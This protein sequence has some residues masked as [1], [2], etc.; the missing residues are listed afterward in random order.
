MGALA[1]AAALLLGLILA[2][3]GAWPLSIPLF[4]Y[5]FWGL[6]FRQDRPQE[7]RDTQQ[8]KPRGGGTGKTTV[9]GVALLGLS[10]VALSQGGQFSVLVFG[11][12]GLALLFRDRI[13]LPIPVFAAKP[14]GDSTLL[15][16]TLLPFA[17]GTVT[18][19]KFLTRDVAGVLSSVNEPMVIDASKPSVFLISTFFAIDRSQAAEK[20]G[21]RLRDLSLV[22]SPLDGYIVPVDSLDAA[23]FLGTPLRRVKVDKE[24]WK[25]SVRTLPYDVLVLNPRGGLVE[26]LG[27]YRKTRDRPTT[28]KMIAP[29]VR[30]PTPPLTWEAVKAFEGRIAWPEPD[31]MAGFAASLSA[32][33]GEPMALKLPNGSVT[34]EGIQ[35]QTF[36]GRQIQL[37]P[38]Q[39]RALVGIYE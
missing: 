27:L 21:T 9:L 25:H 20:A 31:D 13:R 29:F 17:W 14:V 37:K 4:L 23:A 28:A 16:S 36:A 1:K 34:E 5:A 33:R 18:E 22:L 10:L 6:L 11:G 2:G 24:D 3:A 32:K 38:S 12:A 35:V 7:Y 30:P 19:V 15:R 8:G 26:S 39:L